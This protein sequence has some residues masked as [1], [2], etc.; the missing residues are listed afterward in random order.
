MNTL[1]STSFRTLTAGAILSALVFS[2]APV[3]R[4]ADVTAPPQV[5][6]KFGDLKVSTSQGAAAL[7]S[8]IERAAENVCSRMYVS[9]VAYQAHKYTCLPKVIGDAVIKVDRPALSAVFA[10]HYGVSASVLLAAAQTR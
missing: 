7:Y 2:F 4:A 10:S 3:S 9:E 5:I 6:V 8:R 1:P